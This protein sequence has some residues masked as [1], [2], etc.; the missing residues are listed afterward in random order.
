MVHWDVLCLEGKSGLGE[1]EV[2]N[3]VNLAANIGSS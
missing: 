3:L 1:I 2:L